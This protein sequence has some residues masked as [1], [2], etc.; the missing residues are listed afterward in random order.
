MLLGCCLDGDD[1]AGIDV[2]GVFEVR[3][4]GDE[5]SWFMEIGLGVAVMVQDMLSILVGV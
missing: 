2:G 3:G 4:C 1:V 5:L